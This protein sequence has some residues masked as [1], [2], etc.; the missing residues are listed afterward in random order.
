MD[1]YNKYLKYKNKYLELKKTQIGGDKANITYI[2][3]LNRFLDNDMEQF[4]NPIYGYIL[5][6]IG[7]ISNNYFL[8]ESEF[9]NSPESNIIKKICKKLPSGIQPNNQIMKIKPIDI[10]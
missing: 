5:C 1:Y 2:H 7:F 9:I 6:E 10:W 8:N 3:K 4:L